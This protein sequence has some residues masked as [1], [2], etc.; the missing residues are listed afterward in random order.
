VTRGYGSAPTKP[1]FTT[2]PNPQDGLQGLRHSAGPR[3]HRG[4]GVC[5]LKG[6][7]A[8]LTGTLLIRG[9]HCI[10]SL[11]YHVIGNGACNE[12]L[13]FSHNPQVAVR[14]GGSATFAFA[15]AQASFPPAPSFSAD[16]R[17]SPRH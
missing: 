16:S 6:S 17:S 14:Y 9:A 12:D 13:R 15:P 5:R 4:D 11:L 8:V 3:R 7:A 10:V 2:T 1:G